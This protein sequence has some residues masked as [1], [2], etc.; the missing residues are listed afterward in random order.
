MQLLCALNSASILV[1]QNVILLCVSVCIHIYM[2]LNLS[3]YLL[4]H[5]YHKFYLKLI[6]LVIATHE[7]ERI[8]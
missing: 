6:N 8:G 4:I 2:F 5:G 1:S 7:G 3:L